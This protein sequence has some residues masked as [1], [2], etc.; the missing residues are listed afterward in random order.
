MI[1]MFK[2]YG[3]LGL[4]GLFM[5]KAI[6]GA[7]AQNMQRAIETVDRRVNSKTNRKDFLHYVL[8]AME[9]EKGM[10]RAE[11]NVNTFSLSIAGSES[12]ATLL[13]GFVFHTLAHPNIHEE[14]VKEV[15]EAFKSE[16]EIVMAN[17]HGLTYLNAVL[18]ECLR[19]Y[20]PVAV[21]LP[22][23]VPDGGE[24]IDGR[25]VPASTTVGVN[26]YAC[27]HDPRNFHRPDDF[28]PERWMP[29][30]KNKF[31]FS[32][33]HR[34]C[35]QPFSLG[36]RNCLGKNLAWAEVRLI[37]AHLIYLFDMELDASVS[38]RWMERQ[39]VWGFW[40]KPPLLVH[41]TPRQKI[42]R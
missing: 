20:P 9:T 15:M 21:T 13:C 1:Q 19:I 22:R 16:Q 7:R 27:Y 31:P 40:D 41:L 35:L 3:L 4:R 10:S 12:S 37:A 5:P 6:A 36:P 38:N 24:V 23:V 14:L 17:V 33:D 39:K 34:N 25:Y 2:Y 29:G 18:Q 42:S 30:A 8:A 28:L 11:M 32:Q 26:H